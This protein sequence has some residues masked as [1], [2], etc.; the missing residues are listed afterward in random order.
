ME[1]IEIQQIGTNRYAPAGAD[2]V[3]LYATNGAQGLTLAQLV[4]AVCVHRGAHLEARAVTRM[5]KMTAN[6]YYLEAMSSVCSQLAGGASLDDTADVP[7]SYE[8]RRASRPCTIQRFLESECGVTPTL[9]E[10]NKPWTY[11]QRLATINSLKTAMDKANTTSQ[12]DVIELQSIVNWRDVTFNASGSVVAH[13]GNCGM[14]MAE[15]I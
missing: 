13:Y 6:N 7:D 5:N 1:T 8:M 11:A 10:T 9:P 3:C 15:N 12:E 14:N 4:S 2:A